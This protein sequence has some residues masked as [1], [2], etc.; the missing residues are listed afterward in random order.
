M[1][2]A[3]G[4][5]CWR[6]KLVGVAD[7]T[8]A[9]A[10]LTQSSSRFPRHRAIDWRALAPKWS[11]PAAL[12]AIR[13]TIV[14]PGLF[15]LAHQVIGNPQMATFAAFGGFATLVL[16]NFGGNRRDKLRAH[17]M[18]AVAGSVLLA[19][20]TAVA[21]STALAAIV[22][23]PVTFAVFFAGVAG[24]NAA[25]G[26]TG[27][28]LA[29]IL[30]AAS[31]G[32][33]SMIPDRLAGWWLASV[34][35]TLAVLLLSPAPPADSLRKAA[36]ELARKL[37]DQLDSA[38]K[39]TVTSEQIRGSIAAKNRMLAAFTAAPYRPTGLA[40]TDQA[41][42]NAIELLEWCTALI[43]D[44]LRER[45]DLRAAPG[46]DRELVATARLM[47]L[48][49]ASLIE[50][51]DASL[52]LELL[53][54]TR[55]YSTRELARM[56][57]VDDGFEDA[58]RLS[59]HAQAIGIAVRAIG[60]DVLI[61]ARKAD[62]KTI[63]EQRRRWFGAASDTDA[64]ERRLSGAAGAVRVAARHASLRSVWFVNSAR[65]SL[66]LAAAVAIAGAGDVQHGFWVVLGTLSV[67]RT[68]AAST[69]STALRAFAGTAGGFV[70]GAALLLWIGTGSAALW[71]ALPVAV[72]VAAYA[73]GTAP[74]AVGQAA[75]TVVVAVLFNLIAP[76]GWKVGVVRIEDVALGCAVSIV[77]GVL[78]WPRGVS[79]VVGDDLADAFRAGA[80]YLAQ[81]MDWALGS[82]EQ[83]PDGGGA[84]V[85]AGIRLEDALRGYLAEQGSKR[86]HKEQLWRLVGGSLRLRL[87]A[88]TLAGMPQ[89]AV[90]GG[91]AREVFALQTRQLT[92]WY[93]NLAI[94]LSRSSRDRVASL[95][96][97]ELDGASV[98]ELVPG[99]RSPC[100]TVSVHEQL[101]HLSDHLSDLVG[102]AREV[103]AVRRRPW[104]R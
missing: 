56:L 87:T 18:L 32:T 44:G 93:D 43:V 71:V 52:D 64:G 23:V 62:P 98:V 70:V 100:W 30:P 74:F 63:A 48:D 103:A 84:V 95:E 10:D 50:G 13:A 66:A 104:W 49:I 1:D 58:A 92:N 79:A 9:G 67:L 85:S 73:P 22:T 60:A 53:E 68:S 2:R 99:S 89:G 77:V 101:Y 11:K 91:H 39:G 37:A 7:G 80:S 83:V 88:N 6:Y 29:Y 61:A 78:F 47:L 25:S 102:P 5:P 27:A 21:S 40:T 28:L 76:I 15:A 20:G 26:G 57:P 69:G 55:I 14:V 4:A 65:G 34:A 17:L 19:I 97:P 46:A 81:A 54:Q 38:L 35:G 3:R 75:F 86:L 51:K 41:L 24:P 94:E 12:R 82:R 42:A 96:P 16:A 59:F 8:G 45:S 31:P 72:F 33:V 90:Q 36:A